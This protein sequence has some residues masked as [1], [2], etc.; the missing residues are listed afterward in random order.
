MLA[1]AGVFLIVGV[2]D[3]QGIF[4]VGVLG[5]EASLVVHVVIT[6]PPVELHEVEVVE[7]LV[8][9]LE[10]GI[11][12]EQAHQG[13]FGQRVVVKVVLLYHSGL[14]EGFLQYGVALG[15]LLGSEGQLVEVVFAGQSLLQLVFLL[16]F[17][18]DG[19]GV[20]A[21]AVGHE[22]VAHAADGVLFVVVHFVV[23]HGG[24]H[25]LV[26]A[27]PVVLILA[28]AP[29]L[30]E[31]VFAGDDGLLIIEIP[32][33]TVVGVGCVGRL[34]LFAAV[35][36]AATVVITADVAA[37]LACAGYG[38]GLLCAQLF[39]ALFLKLYGLVDDGQTLAFGHGGQGTHTVLHKDGF[40]G[41]SQFVEHLGAFGGA[42]ISLVLLAYD[43]Y[44]TVVAAAGLGKTFLGPVDIAH[45][46]H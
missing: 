31:E 36:G 37:V 42:L 32:V 38:V 16:V 33:G 22:R 12:V 10:L 44:G 45:L 46:Q 2:I 9:G 7:Q 4:A 8:H 41:L 29:L 35:V 40:A 30:A 18:V 27:T 26:A 21:E 28:G 11:V 43:A 1:E 24:E 15:H 6:L 34:L 25:R 23:V 5:G 19:G 14:K 17:L 20:V 3:E 13:A 39:L